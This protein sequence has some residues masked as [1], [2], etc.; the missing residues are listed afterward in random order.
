MV[1]LKD[2]ADMA[3][4]S[5]ATVSY[6]INGRN[7]KVGKATYARIQ[8]II[9]ETGYVPSLSARSLVNRSS[10]II[11]MINQS[12]ENSPES[13]L[14]DPFHSAFMSGLETTLRESGYFLMV[15]SIDKN[16]PFQSLVRSWNLDGI[17][18]TGLFN[19]EF[20]LEVKKV[21]VP[22]VL[23]DSYVN[24]DGVTSVS[25]EDEQGSYLATR[26]ILGKGHKNIAFA[27]PIIRKGGV[28]EERF[29]GYKRALQ[30]FNIP[31]NPA[32][33]FS[34]EITTKEGIA[35][36]E[37]LA[38][39]SEITAIVTTADI[40][41]AGIMAGL[42]NKGVEV[43]R[44]KSVIGFDDVFFSPLLSPKLTTIHQDALQKGKV[45]A[46]LLIQQ[47]DNKEVGP[48]QVV[49]PVSLIERESVKAI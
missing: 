40:L 43:P 38:G 2:L 20:F 44:D 33:V 22:F 48:Q 31:I 5:V 19:D 26:Y 4:V 29:N 34:Q 41:A 37:K 7:D 49:L 8:K 16:T 39:F 23:I 14:N 15:R 24:D 9:S 27:G 36:G 13:F 10:K 1:T 42:K 21:G 11:G 45:A 18:F 35:L 47:I 46:G 30:D 3:G 32:W 6:V 17:V 12:L 28:V 25:I